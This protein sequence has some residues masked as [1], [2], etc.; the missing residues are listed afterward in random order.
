MLVNRARRPAL[1][2]TEEWIRAHTDAEDTEQLHWLSDGNDLESEDGSSQSGDFADENRDPKTPTLRTF[3][4]RRSTARPILEHHRQLSTDTLK[5]EDFRVEREAAKMSTGDDAPALDPLGEMAIEVKSS[6][7][8]KHV[9]H[10]R[11]TSSADSVKQNAS[12]TVLRDSLPRTVSQNND[13]VGINSS[14]EEV[15]PQFENGQFVSES[16]TAKMDDELPPPPPPKD[17][18][19][20]SVQATEWT[21]ASL[22]MPARVSF[23]LPEGPTSA[24]P[25]PRPG[26]QKKKIPWKGK[27]IVVLIPIDD[28]RGQPGKPL[29]PMTP[30][31]VQKMLREYEQLGYNVS[32]F[33]L[34]HA[35]DSDSA[36]VQG[37]SRVGWPTMDE[38]QQDRQAGNWRISIPDRREWDA[39]VE[40]LKEAKLRALGVSLGDDEPPPPSISPAVSLS[41]T[42]SVQQYPPL[43]FSPPMPSS[44]TSSHLLQHTNPFSPALMAGPGPSITSQSSNVPSIASPASM[45]SQVYGKYNTRQSISLASGDRFGSPFQLGHSHSPSMWSPQ[46]MLYQQGLARGGS[47]SLHN[48]GSVGS[49]F[50]LDGYFSGP[51]DMNLQMH[52]HQQNLQQQLQQ[53]MQHASML[54]TPSLQQQIPEDDEAETIQKSPSKTPEASQFIKRNDDSL[55]KEID[56]AEAALEGGEFHLEGQMTRQLEGKTNSP[57]SDMAIPMVDNDANRVAATPTTLADN[58]GGPRFANGEA[59][60]LHHPQPHSR[61][62]SL[63]QRPFLD[64][65]EISTHSPVAKHDSPDMDTTLDNSL[66]TSEVFSGPSRQRSIS[67]STNPWA[68]EDSPAEEPTQPKRGHVRSTSNLNVAAPEFKPSKPFN[69]AA[70]EFKFYTSHEFMPSAST[71]KLNVAAP[72]FK[73]NPSNEFKPSHFSFSTGSLPPT[74]VTAPVFVPKTIESSHSVSNSVTGLSKINVTAPPF[75]PGQSD[76]SFSSMGPKFKPDAP[77]F[78]PSASL[79]SSVGDPQSASEQ[80]FSPRSSI[81][82]NLNLNLTNLAGIVKPAKKSKAVPIIRPDSAERA[83]SVE[84]EENELREDKDG[85]ITQGDGRNK[86]AKGAAADGDSVPLFASPTPTPEPESV[87]PLQETTREQSPPK[88]TNSNETKPTLADKENLD[89][90][91]FEEQ[92]NE[93]HVVDT[94]SNKALRPNS[95]FEDSP[96]YDG[97]GWAPWEFQQEKQ[98]QEFSTAAAFPVQTPQD[99]SRP[100]EKE[101]EV[102]K[103]VAFTAGGSPKQ[104]TAADKP[105]HTRKT[106]LSALAKPFEFSTPSWSKFGGSPTKNA[107]PA[108]APAA[109]PAAK[110]RVVSGGLRASRFATSPSPPPPAV[111]VEEEEDVEEAATAETETVPDTP[112]VPEEDST[113]DM[114]PLDVEGQSAHQAAISPQ[115]PAAALAEPASPS[116]REPT[117][118]EIDAVMRHMN[119]AEKARP[120]SRDTN[121]PRWHQPSPQRPVQLP[122]DSSPALH[123]PTLPN[124]PD[125]RSD[126]PSPS[127]RR[128]QYVPLPGDMPGQRVFSRVHDD[129]FVHHES[130]T[131]MAYESPIHNLNRPQGDEMPASDWDDVLSRSSDAGKFQSRAQFFDHHVNDLV[132]GLLAERLD[133]VEKALEGIQL[134]LAALAERGVVPGT[135]RGLER[136]SLSAELQESDADDED[137]DET[138]GH[139]RSSS[140]RKVDR[141][142]ER[143]RAVVSEALTAHL[144]SGTAAT[145]LAA[146]QPNSVVT[147]EMRESS[148]I[149][150]ALED[151]QEQFGHSMHLDFRGEDLR[152]I[153]EEAVQARLPSPSKEKDLK[154]EVEITRIAELEAKVLELTR[155]N[156]TADQKVEEEVR[157]RRAAEDR[158]AEVQRLLRISSEE[159]TRLR[160]SLDDRD[161]KLKSIDE[162]RSK[163]TM[164]T[165]LL[166]ADAQNAKKNHAELSNKLNALEGD[167]RAARQESTKWQSEAERALE[168]MKKQNDAAEVANETNAQLSRTVEGLKVQL[169]ENVR[170]RETMRTKLGNLQENMARAAQEIGQENAKRTRREQEL[171]ARQEVLDAR[172][173]AEARTR[174]RLERE[175]ERLESTERDAMRAVNESKRLE[176][177]LASL[178]GE[179]HESEKKALKYQR[180]FEEARESGLSEVQRTRHYMQ[181]EIESANTQVNIVRQDLED[182]IAR[183]RGEIDSQKLEADTAKARA[184]MM[185]EEAVESKAKE[186]KDIER[187][188]RDEI[189]DLQTR[190]ERDLS[191]ANED[192]QR[193]EQHLLERLSLSTSKT[194]HLQDRVTHLEE[195]LDIAKAAAAAAAQAARD[196]RPSTTTAS[197]EAVKAARKPTMEL[198]GKISPQALRESIMVLQ[199]QLQDREQ[200]IESLDAKLSTADLDAPSKIAKLN[201]EVTWLRE[202]LAVRVGDLQ[203]L[204]SSTSDENVD[205]AAL[206]DAAIRL[207]AGLEMEIAVRDRSGSAVGAALG[208]VIAS[209]RSRIGDVAVAASPRVAQVVGPMAAAWGSWRRGQVQ[210]S[211][212]QDGGSAAGTAAAPAAE[213]TPSRERRPSPQSFLSGLLT[214]PASSARAA[215]PATMR[216]ESA[217]SASS[218]TSTSQRPQLSAFNSTGRRLT[219]QQLAKER[220]AKSA[221]SATVVQPALP[222][223][224]P[225]MRM[226]SYDSDAPAR[227]GDATGE[228][229]EEEEDFGG[230]FDDDVA[231]VEDELMGVGRL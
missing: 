59:P 60:V 152:N 109:A 88:E 24:S 167:L 203:D 126:A 194:E 17:I 147:G 153:V 44:S 61:G 50:S 119:E 222:T 8:R 162:H 56:A 99:N 3:L 2:I 77:S 170:V 196:R 120:I 15:S 108:V 230:D 74:V 138:E 228:V 213:G 141:K 136:R 39:Y 186:V 183:L 204:I 211:E 72:E 226:A 20:E 146:Q 79:N 12:Q 28:A 220:G 54:R 5:A 157:T 41:R 150:Q 51:S 218:G 187:K 65:E 98:I 107:A 161:A 148:Q 67:N 229:E 118:E 176:E 171:I 105:A 207:K 128:F 29:A 227:E 169:E 33:D 53:Q 219:A 71:S 174:E 145:Q 11:T 9:R 135:R 86:R 111:P 144:S 116:D 21:A 104:P 49:P 121:T 140:P 80:P 123:L 156:E 25:I 103:P 78:T 101:Q 40:E 182:Q 172:L 127:P 125:L 13:A 97:K 10:A 173:Q 42:A 31:D 159:E 96:D 189:E 83:K 201:D 184:E 27:N 221:K 142:L 89:V 177:L 58:H 206:R 155:K 134:S 52:Q 223:T 205:I 122:L 45:H 166:E 202:L 37:Q 130:L 84:K 64:S 73:F 57:H 214:P 178:K 131:G 193:S 191:V 192:A 75:V 34:S 81:F 216:R 1:G 210:R 69:V 137:D 151:L 165:A 55:Q 90:G 132:G 143:I 158:L 30:T 163:S 32:G 47:P 185:L 18:P 70:P 85:R 68:E 43:P 102:T 82:G 112:V 76:F 46:Q 164:K 114:V 225:M 129:P 168:A 217:A 6:S 154:T 200:T 133:P 95:N 26:R 208:P 14:V 94:P 124:L 209:A 38:I 195:K 231:G 198:P 63:S 180:E 66:I 91:G 115:S 224:P 106:S 113:Q 22:P 181:I 179:L 62:H 87:M 199:E 175:I 36:L 48:L 188:Y 117:F 160:E 35:E 93:L 19:E 215:T 92:R 4:E 149:L 212:S 7:P 110:P 100:V 190:H 197:P 139:R 16:T 23:N